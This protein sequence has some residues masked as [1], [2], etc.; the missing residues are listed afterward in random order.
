M[1]LINGLFKFLDIL[2]SVYKI[3]ELCELVRIYI[4]IR[5]VI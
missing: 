4:N 1:V 3:R 5:I 2:K